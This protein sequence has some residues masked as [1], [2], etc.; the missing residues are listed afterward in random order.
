M[1]VFVESH[2]VARSGGKP[3]SLQH[4]ANDDDIKTALTRKETYSP[5]S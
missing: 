1:E 4:K 3:Y 2:R 5:R